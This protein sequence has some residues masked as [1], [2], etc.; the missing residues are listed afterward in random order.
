MNMDQS[1][2]VTSR[3]FVWLVGP[4]L[5]PVLNVS[6]QIQQPWPNLGDGNADTLFRGSSLAGPRPGIQE[7]QAVEF[8]H[9]VH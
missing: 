5:D 6:T 4:T 3:E 9:K 7:H 8:E 1:M 2:M